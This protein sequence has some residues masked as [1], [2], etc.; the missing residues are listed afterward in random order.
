[1]C[2]KILLITAA[3]SAICAP[4]MAD[5]WNKKTILTVSEPVLIPGKTLMPGKY[6]VK[7]VDSASDR[8]IVQFTNERED[9]VITTVL[10][11]P[12]YRLKPL[13]DTQFGW[14]ETPAGNPPALRAWFYPGD[15]FGQEFAYPKGLSAKIAERTQAPVPTVATE[16]PEELAKA[17]IEIMEPPVVAPKPELQ[18]VEVAVARPPEPAPPPVP[19]VPAPEPPPMPDTASPYPLI[20]LGGLSAVAAGLLLRAAVPVKNR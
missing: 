6:V 20:V 7:L 12:N 4:A 19:V 14:W 11:I 10:A 18:S 15:N 16:K 13:G 17:P 9:E 5:T 1:M 2:C 8:H 3:A